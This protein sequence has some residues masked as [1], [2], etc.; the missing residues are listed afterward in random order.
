MGPSR[1][2][3]V[4]VTWDIRVPVDIRVPWGAGVLQGGGVPGDIWVPWDAGVPWD[5][6]GVSGCPRMVLMFSKTCLD[7]ACRNR[8]GINSEER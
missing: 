2:W 6:H 4:R 5:I 3:D 1:P 8:G 7:G